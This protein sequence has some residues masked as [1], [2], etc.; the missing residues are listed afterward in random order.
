MLNQKVKDLLNTQI[1]K[2]FESAYLYLEMANYYKLSG[3]EGY[4]HW[5]MKQS[6]EELYHGRMIIDYLLDCNSSVK[7]LDISISPRNYIDFIQ[8]LDE[9]LSHEK[10]VTSLIIDI[11]RSCIEAG[12]YRTQN[13]LQWFIKEQK[14]EEV[15]A[16]RLADQMRMFGINAEGLYALDKEAGERK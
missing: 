13:F 2:E 11:Y 5:F 7:L 9:A 14:E 16:Q 6:E 12:D 1:Q 4:A 8:P 10:Y 3:L 15:S